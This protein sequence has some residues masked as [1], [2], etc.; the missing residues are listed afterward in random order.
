MKSRFV[1]FISALVAAITL[2]GC[3]CSCHSHDYSIVKYDETSHWLECECGQ[4]VN[5]IKHNISYSGN[6]TSHWKVCSDCGYQ[7]PEEGH[8]LEHK[9]DETN[10]YDICKE[11]QHKFSIEPHEYEQYGYDEKHHWLECECGQGK[12]IKEPHVFDKKVVDTKYLAI[13]ANDSHPNTY[14]YSCICGATGK[15]T[16]ESGLP[17]NHEHTYDYKGY[18]TSEYCD[19]CVQQDLEFYDTGMFNSIGEIVFKMYLPIVGSISLIANFA[20]LNDPVTIYKE[21][22]TQ[23][24][25][26]YASGAFTNDKAQTVYVHVKPTAKDGYIVFTCNHQVDYTGHCT[27][28]DDY[29]IC[30]ELTLNGTREVTVY[31]TLNTY[32]S[33]TAPYTGLFEITSESK[34]DGSSARLEDFKNSDGTS[35]DYVFGKLAAVEGET[36]YFRAFTDTTLS[37]TE[38]FNFSVKEVCEDV[39]A[40]VN[41]IEHKVIDDK[42][43]SDLSITILEG[44]I[45]R[46]QRINFITNNGSFLTYIVDDTSTDSFVVYYE[47]IDSSTLNNHILIQDPSSKVLKNSLITNQDEDECIDT[48]YFNYRM[49]SET[50]IGEDI[51]LLNGARVM[52]DV[53]NDQTFVPTGLVSILYSPT[54][55]GGLCPSEGAG[56][57]VEFA[58]PVPTGLFK[59]NT[60]YN[61][62][63]RFNGI[64]T[65]GECALVA[66]K[67]VAESIRYH[68]EVKFYSDKATNGYLQLATRYWAATVGKYEKYYST[69]TLS[70]TGKDYESSYIRYDYFLE[71]V[72][73][74][75]TPNGLKVTYSIF[76]TSWCD[77]GELDKA[78]YLWL[79]DNEGGLNSFPVYEAGD[80]YF[81]LQHLTTSEP[82]LNVAVGFAY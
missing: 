10:H 74:V 77:P 39:T 34:V 12:E 51:T 63:L 16:F 49:F 6:N 8:H 38:K 61:V 58:C 26:Y 2:S 54:V 82:I 24:I 76:F 7:S 78:S 70:D 60:I 50:E 13:P 37:N 11:C 45:T 75:D 41:S 19:D 28:C 23:M 40:V 71:I 33:F 80:D 9:H 79:I 1:T 43:Y 64:F 42:T 5:V 67:K 81:I 4:K 31:T 46:G 36:Y 52:L 53:F 47:T 29:D 25:K 72:D 22:G 65:I 69:I 18:C 14:Y 56:I 62:L 27:Q 32:F 21:D 15:D 3:N 57:E 35:A 66:S 55:E 44:S 20:V 17:L 59:S 68:D 48:L 73:M 30:N